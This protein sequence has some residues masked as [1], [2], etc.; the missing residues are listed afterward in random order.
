MIN[1]KISSRRGC[2]CKLLHS[3]SKSP[4]GICRGKYYL[5]F[6]CK[7]ELLSSHWIKDRLLDRKCFMTIT[8]SIQPTSAY[9]LTL[10]CPWHH[11]HDART[12]DRSVIHARQRDGV[13]DQGATVAET[14]SRTGACV[15]GRRKGVSPTTMT[16]RNF[17]GGKRRLRVYGPRN[18]L[19]S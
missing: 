17:P 5:T 18:T 13:S 6:T 10:G 14:S 16:A 1:V 3:V 8:S 9:Y 2:L 11:C 12:P 4:C 15:H 7:V 19:G